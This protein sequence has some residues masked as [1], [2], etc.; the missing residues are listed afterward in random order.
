MR[1]AKLIGYSARADGEAC[2]GVQDVL[3]RDV[4]GRLIERIGVCCFKALEHGEHAACQ[5]R[6]H[7]GTIGVEH[8]SLKGR[9]PLELADVPKPELAQLVGKCV[10]KTFGAACVEFH[11][12]LSCGAGAALVPLSI[13]GAH[14]CCVRAYVSFNFDGSRACSRGDTVHYK[15]VRKTCPSER[16]KS[17]MHQTISNSQKAQP[18]ES[19]T[20]FFDV[21]GTLI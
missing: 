20:L 2:A 8:R 21:D 16:R 18:Q 10:F 19:A 6:E 14:A 7:A 4:V 13:R 5:T 12:C 15:M 17:A 11:G 1:V 3:P 9:A